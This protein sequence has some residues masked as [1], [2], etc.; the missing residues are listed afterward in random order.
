VRRPL[1]KAAPRPAPCHCPATRH[2]R[3]R[4]STRQRTPPGTNRRSPVQAALQPQSGLASCSRT[5]GSLSMFHVKRRPICALSMAS[6]AGL[7][8][9]GR[10]PRWSP[11]W[12][13]GQV[14]SSPGGSAPCAVHVIAV[15]PGRVD[16]AHASCDPAW[17][18]RQPYAVRAVLHWP[19]RASLAG[20]CFTRYPRDSWWQPSRQVRLR[21]GR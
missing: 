12:Q 9:R 7:G 21:A 13:V 3:R 5:T 6:R 20:P 18:T 19:G 4:S 14:Y 11:S 17:R 8:S 10:W 15:L 1:G 16:V 2:A